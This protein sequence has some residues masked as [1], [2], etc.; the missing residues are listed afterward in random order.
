MQ[1]IRNNSLASADHMLA[2]PKVFSCDQ[3]S[4]N[5]IMHCERS[6]LVWDARAVVGRFPRGARLKLAGN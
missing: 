3:Y 4:I 1:A 5:T 6:S 2:Y